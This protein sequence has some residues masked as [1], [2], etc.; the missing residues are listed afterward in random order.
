[1]RRVGGRLEIKAARRGRV[2]VCRVVE[3]R[4]GADQRAEEL[5]AEQLFVNTPARALSAA[6]DAH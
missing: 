4:K 3:R 2:A 5:V 6:A 1:M